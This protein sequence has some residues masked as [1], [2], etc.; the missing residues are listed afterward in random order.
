VQVADKPAL[1]EAIENR[2]FLLRF[3]GGKSGQKAGTRYNMNVYYFD[4]GNSV[5][6]F[7]VCFMI[8]CVVENE[9]FHTNINLKMGEMTQLQADFDKDSQ[10]KALSAE[11]DDKKEKP[12]KAFK[13]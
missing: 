10:L 4:N 9:T 3:E 8:A 5:L 7:C 6:C 13:F 2:K 1:Q 12:K 11:N